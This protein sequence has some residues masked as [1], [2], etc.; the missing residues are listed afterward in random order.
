MREGL[1]AL[2]PRLWRFALMLSGSR[3]AADDLAQK[4]C[5]RALENAGKFEAG[6][7]LDRWMFTLTRRIW[8][9][10][11]RSEAVRR[12]NGLVPVEE[13]ELAANSASSEANIFTGEVFNA[14]RNLPESQ[15]E[16]VLL[17]Y[18]EGYAYKDAAQMLEI[19][20]GTVMSR[21]AAARKSIA[22]KFPD[23]RA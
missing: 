3:V 2:Y 21:L 12:G 7:H 4:A 19:P 17:V 5:T 8:L 9:N 11:L 1:P 16:T 10:E 6:T 20:I 13:V 15:R 22:Q 18:V 14:I 23:E